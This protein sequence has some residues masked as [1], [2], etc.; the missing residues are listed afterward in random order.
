M[1]AAVEEE[2]E[3]EEGR[4]K[5][6]VCKGAGGAGGERSVYEGLACVRM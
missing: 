3:E 2:Q 1:R 5:E 6:V 4:G